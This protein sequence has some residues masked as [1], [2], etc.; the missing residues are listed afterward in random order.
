MS[1]DDAASRRGRETSRR[2]VKFQATMEDL[3]GR[4]LMSAAH[5]PLRAPHV[6][7]EWSR[8]GAREP[9]GL[10][11]GSSA[12][13]LAQTPTINVTPSINIQ[14]SPAAPPPR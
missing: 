12:A 2:R 14:P 4:V 6:S 9:A 13:M 1:H 7:S 8:P 3:E 5:R 11:P 10:P